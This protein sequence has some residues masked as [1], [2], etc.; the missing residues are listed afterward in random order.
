[1]QH[2]RHKFELQ[3]PIP[4]INICCQFELLGPVR[5]V[6]KTSLDFPACIRRHPAITF[7]R[8]SSLCCYHKGKSFKLSTYG[9]CPLYL[10]FSPLSFSGPVSGPRFS[11]AVVVIASHKC[12]SSIPRFPHGPCSYQCLSLFLPPTLFFLPPFQTFQCSM[13]IG[14]FINN[15]PLLCHCFSI[16]M[17]YNNYKQVCWNRFGAAVCGTVGKIITV[18]F[19]NPNKLY[20]KYQCLVK[21][22]F[23]WRKLWQ[24]LF[25]NDT[26]WRK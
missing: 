8:Q 18:Y 15:P 24:K 7:R 25:V 6:M 12:H 3:C 21:Y 2:E 11:S 17:H 9:L 1:M 23:C 10:T 5:S 22:T 26:L 4:I 16:Y 19:I 13:S 14:A 20:G